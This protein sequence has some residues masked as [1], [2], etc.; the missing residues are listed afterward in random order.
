MQTAKHHKYNKKT[1]QK[2]KPALTNAT[3]KSHAT[4]SGVP[5]SEKNENQR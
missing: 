2:F 3:G 5:E 4:D 1:G